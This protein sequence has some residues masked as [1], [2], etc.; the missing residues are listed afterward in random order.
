MLNGSRGYVPLYIV[1]RMIIMYVLYL[2]I[3]P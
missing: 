1:F 2:D 3:S